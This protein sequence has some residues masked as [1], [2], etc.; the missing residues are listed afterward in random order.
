M[1]VLVLYAPD[2]G[3]NLAAFTKAGVPY[4]PIINRRHVFCTRLSKVGALRWL[5][6]HYS[7]RVEAHL[8]P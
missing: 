5:L 2:R 8:R 6:T 7:R 4:F 1:P 3:L